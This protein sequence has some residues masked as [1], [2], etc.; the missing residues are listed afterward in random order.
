MDDHIKDRIK[1]YDNAA[2]VFKNKMDELTQIINKC[3]IMP[4]D[5]VETTIVKKYLE[6]GEV[7]AV[8]EY[9]NNKG[10]RIK[11]SSHIGERRYTTND[12]TNVIDNK[13]LNIEEE[14]YKGID[15]MRYIDRMLIKMNI[16][17]LLKEYK[18]D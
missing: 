14:L 18:V 11:T 8:T 13:N 1:K 12:I 10:Y 7:K 17:K 3:T 6:C 4:D 15:L 5:T 2:I 9:I 16:N